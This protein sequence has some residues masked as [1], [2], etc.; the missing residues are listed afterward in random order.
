MN[1]TTEST[2]QERIAV[3]VGIIVAV[4]ETIREL[5]SVPSGHLYARFMGCMSVETYEGIIGLLV[6]SGV[7]RREPSHLLVWTGNESQSN[8][9]PDAPDASN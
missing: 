2:E 9:V 5:G 7:V 8:A 1:A 4:A 3:V 6:R